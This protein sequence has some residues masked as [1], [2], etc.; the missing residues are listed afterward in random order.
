MKA[1]QRK[2][3]NHLERPSIVFVTNHHVQAGE[4]IYIQQL[5]IL[6][7]KSKRSSFHRILLC[8]EGLRRMCYDENF[9]FEIRFV[10]E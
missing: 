4:I 2:Q 10:T 3:L 7:I 8:N 5:K 9:T 6:R 1:S